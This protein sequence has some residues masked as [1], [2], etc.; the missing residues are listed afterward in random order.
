[1]PVTPSIRTFIAAITA[2]IDSVELVDGVIFYR[3]SY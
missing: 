3:A 1:M 2:L